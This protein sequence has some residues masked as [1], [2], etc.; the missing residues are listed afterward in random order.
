MAS[1]TI[2]ARSNLVPPLSYH[3]CM[4]G[5]ST[6]TSNLERGKACL[7]CRR[8]KMRCDGARPACSQ[9]VRSNLED[10]EYI[11]GGPTQSQLLEQNIAELEARIREL[12]GSDAEVAL[13]DPHSVANNSSPPRSVN[14]IPPTER[15]IQSFIDHASC[16]GFFLHP[17]RFLPNL[18]A[19][20][21]PIDR[22]PVPAALVH[23]VYLIGI[24]CTNDPVLKQQEPHVLAR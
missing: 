8:R 2:R 15:I 5:P 1:L 24:V 21:P 14:A 22:S 10:C 17:G 20:I 6:A 16:F 23:T 11:D 12:E 3:P 13:H 18:R 4:A 19:S 9:C 7:R